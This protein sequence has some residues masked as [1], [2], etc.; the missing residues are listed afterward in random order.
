MIQIITLG[1]D[2]EFFV[3][4]KNGKPFPATP[5]TKGSK[6]NPIPIIDY[7]FFEQRDNLSFEGNIPP[8]KTKKEFVNNMNL[9][10]NYFQ[11]KVERHGYSLSPNGVER[12]SKKYLVTD[13]GMEFGCSKVV[14]A[15]D[16]LPEEIIE[17]PTPNL[18]ALN[19]RVA[20][21]HIH[22]GYIP[23]EGIPKSFTDILIGRLFD[24]FLTVPSQIIKPEPERLYTYG[25]WGM[26]RIKDY[27]VECRTLS[28][29][30]TLSG[31]LPWVWDKIMEMQ[32]FIN[33][34]TYE[35]LLK[36]VNKRYIVAD[37]P[38]VMSSLFNQIFSTFDNKNLNYDKYFD[39]TLAT[40][41]AVFVY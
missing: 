38:H 36:I 9:L 4:D 6:D 13:E 25:K 12:F 29:F 35:D 33:G 17:K 37:D 2:P 31:N 22:I 11:N 20:G 39:P 14:S 10:R 41:P 32:D 16:S 28:S 34:N 21:F 18:T 1:A 8:S 40:N 15:W 3:L 7:G 26:I 30:F 5:F 24:L 23:D 19:Y 27:G